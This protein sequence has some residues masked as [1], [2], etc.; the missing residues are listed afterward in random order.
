MDKRFI[1]KICPYCKTPF[2]EGDEIVTCSVCDMPHHLSCWQENDGCT[3]FG[4]SGEMTETT[5]NMESQSRSDDIGAT[6]DAEHHSVN[7]EERQ[8][9]EN[10]QN[11]HCEDMSSYVKGDTQKDCETTTTEIHAKSERIS[12]SDTQN[13]RKNK[14]CKF[15]GGRI[16]P[17]S[18][19]CLSCGR[20]FF[21]FH[22]KAVLI[23]SI[24]LV[25]IA[26]AGLNAF[27][28]I[29]H[30][31]SIESYTTE[32]TDLQQQVNTKD[33][34]ISNLDQ[35]IETKD[36]TISAQ[37]NKITRL[38]E[39]AENYDDICSSMSGGNIGYASSNF[40]T[41]ESIIVLRKSEVD[42]KF[43]LT[44]NWSNG[45]NVSV[46]YSSFAAS[47]SFDNHSWYT[48]TTMTIKPAFEGVTVVTFSN[49]VNSSTFKVLIIVT[50]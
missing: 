25:I 10:V 14:F 33:A 16:D 5:E 2:I 21:R 31:K 17:Q 47:V 28:Y 43:T 24:A 42:R 19:K 46:S 11:P 37:K 26:L 6:N 20:Q 34:I 48:S 38:E 35:Q 40:K 18:K 36:A 9:T 23:V 45:G 27:Q 3:T 7:S 39:K 1:G 22:G 49:D 41:S 29:I 44:A 15:C 50:E 32:I 13:G 4:C 8:P 30:C 12:N